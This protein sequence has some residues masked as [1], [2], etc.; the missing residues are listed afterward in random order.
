MKRNVFNCLLKEA[1]K[2]AIV[3]LVGRHARAGGPV[4]K[5]IP[6]TMLTVLSLRAITRNQQSKVTAA[7]MCCMT[8]GRW[9][10]LNAGRAAPDV[11][12]PWRHIALPRRRTGD[13]GD[14]TAG[15]FRCWTA[16]GYPGPRWRHVDDVYRWRR[17]IAGA[18]AA[19]T[20]VKVARSRSKGRRDDG[21]HRRGG[22]WRVIPTGTQ[23][24]GWRPADISN[25][26]NKSLI[27]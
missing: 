16:P 8:A 9:S 14:C 2:V 18:P 26:Y 27:N 13:A 4:T 15:R 7:H 22:K 5:I 3:T 17:E 21:E 19:T 10:A 23:S 6:L 25:I 12:S 24:A 11:T 20:K 1:R